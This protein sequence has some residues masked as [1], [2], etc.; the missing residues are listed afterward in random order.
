[1]L[2]LRFDASERVSGGRLAGLLIGL[3]GVVVLVGIDVAGRTYELVGT[4]AIRLQRSA[5]PPARW[6]SSA[7]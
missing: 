5:M 3:A 4:A 1:M 6:S 2:A 7:S